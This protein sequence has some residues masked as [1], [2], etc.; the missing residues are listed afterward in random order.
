MQIHE[1]LAQREDTT[2][3]IETPV[4]QKWKAAICLDIRPMFYVLHIVEL[5]LFDIIW[6]ST[7]V[8]VCSEVW[9]ISYNLQFP[10]VQ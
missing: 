10:Y 9:P 2:Y 7:Y 6:F 1:V 4:N 8:Y 5:I 3:P